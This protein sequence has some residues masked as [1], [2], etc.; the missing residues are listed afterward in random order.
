[1]LVP[2]RAAP[3]RFNGGVLFRLRRPWRNE[4]GRLP[5]RRRAFGLQQVEMPLPGGPAAK[6]GIR[7]EKWWTL[8]ELVRMLHGETDSIRLEEPGLDEAEFVVSTGSRR[9]FHQAKRSHPN[10]KWSLAALRSEGVLQAM[11]KELEN[12]ANCFVFASSCH[13]P[14]LSELCDAVRSAESVEELERVFLQAASRRRPFEALCEAWSCG[15]PDAMDRLRRVQVRTVDE[16]GLREQAVLG[17][18]VLFRAN[19]T[20]LQET[21]LG[22]IDDSVHKT[23]SRHELREV[24]TARG[25][26]LRRLN[27][28]EDAADAVRNATDAHYFLNAERRL[29]RERLVQREAAKVLVSGLGETPSDTVLVGKAGVGKTACI[30]EVVRTLRERDVPVLVLRLD[31]IP[32]GRSTEQIGRILDLEESPALVLAAAAKSANRPGVLIVD[33]LDAVSTMSGRA[34]GAFEVVEA[35]LEETRGLRPQVPL[36]TIVASREFDWEHDPQLRRLAAKSAESVR[37]AEFEVP[38]VKEILATA[39][40]DPALFGQHQLRV[41]RLAQNLSL[42]LEAEFAASDA[43]V[44]GTAKDLFDRYWSC[45]R[46]A[47]DER[48]GHLA[49]RWTEVVRQVCDEMTS[50]QQLWVAKER[51][52]AIPEQY[53]EQMASEGVLTFDGRGYG[54]GHESFF[55]YCWARS[56]CGRSER[57][58]P[59]LTGAEQ[60]LFRRSQ[61]RQVLVYLRDQDFPRYVQEVDAILSDERIR[62]HIKHLVFALLARVEQPADEEWAIWERWIAPEL[63]A[64]EAGAP[65]QN[66]LPALA[67]R[68]FFGSASWFTAAVERGYVGDWLRSA[69]VQLG[70]VGVDYLLVHHRHSPDRVAALLEPYTDS[71]GP[72]PQRFRAFMGG[73]R[74]GPSRALFDFFLRLVDNGV[75]DDGRATL[76]S[77]DTFWDMLRGLTDDRPEWIAEALGHRL[78]RRLRVRLAGDSIPYPGPLLGYDDAA[79]RMFVEAGANAP[80]SFVEHVLPAVLEASDSTVAG[81]KLPKRDPVWPSLSESSYRSADQT[82]LKCLAQALA[83]VAQVDR[84]LARELIGGLRGRDSHTANYLLLALYRGEPTRYADEAMS[85]LCDEHWRLECGTGPNRWWY[86]ME[87]IRAAFPHCSAS[88]RGRVEALILGYVDR[89]ERT[90]EG[91]LREGR[92]RFAL[93]SAVPTELRGGRAQKLFRELER[94]FGKPLGKEP[95]FEGGVVGPPIPTDGIAKMTDEQWLRALGK[96]SSEWSHRRSLQDLQKGGAWELAGAMARRTEE[97]PERFAR[98]GLRFPADANPAYL[99]GVL[100][101]LEKASVGNDLKLQVCRKALAEWFND[102]GK[103][104]AD[105]L[106]SLE[107]PVPV[108]AIEML[109]RLAVEHGDPNSESWQKESANGR[110]IYDGDIYT[111]GINSTR[112]RTALAIAK[113]I[114]ADRSC[115]P[116]FQPTLERMVEDES[117][118]VLSCVLG[119]LQAVAYHELGFALALL[120]RTNLSE[121]RLLSTRHARYLLRGALFRKFAEV[122]PF[123]ERMID[124]REPKVRQTGARLL[125]IASLRDEGAAGSVA[126]CLQSSAAHRLGVCEVAA[127]NVAESEC[128]TWCERTLAELFDD[129]DT[130]VRKE[131]ATCFRRMESE[132]LDEYAELIGAFCGSRAYRDVPFWLLRALEKSQR[133]LPGVTI[134]ACERFFDR[135]DGPEQGRPAGLRTVVKL[136]FRTYQQHQQ[137]CWGQRSL[138]L[139]DR[140]CLE[141]VY[142]VGKGLDHFDR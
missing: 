117:P 70:D 40:F 100:A 29:I 16:R 27:N 119:T 53:L 24:L 28:P 23:I 18:R 142:E 7:Y 82:C 52:D 137:E 134:M 116:A 89:F 107:S 72:W 22:I 57:L 54:F 17:L 75:L 3:P 105:V 12:D 21:L 96:Y 71:D 36:H 39:G 90:A 9:C 139:I 108:G 37:I 50:S 123:L 69:T 109:H 33:Q 4:V 124:S 114:S 87:T 43:P 140:L 122:Q 59:F 76:A 106:G 104:V 47:V 10:G 34:S 84:S 67:W 91:R 86:A 141:G 128:R 48:A 138:A 78:R 103:S 15:V 110:R 115:L 118:A 94:K 26:A 51:L 113:L 41:L 65:G 13:A 35:L 46:Q 61:V 77:N 79:S 14:E 80:A 11:G 102:C 56:F 49:G 68:A 45:K 85:L 32:G 127:A 88:V 42:F 1:M 6:L 111:S 135:F 129:V 8:S 64:I 25:H 5:A 120:R 97:E 125:G 83:A 130:D 58:V 20:E 99:D 60:H 38:E 19:P 133:P 98:L 63:K 2:L 73:V 95:E 92:A 101:G 93:L 136:I 31:R 112:G 55:D 62:V 30:V 126:Q 66:T 44:F 132:P 74:H 121:D 81:E 131:A